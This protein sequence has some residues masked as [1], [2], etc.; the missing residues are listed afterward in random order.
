MNFFEII[1]IVM[2]GLCP[3]FIFRQLVM[4]LVRRKERATAYIEA[5][6]QPIAVVVCCRNE[7]RVIARL[8]SSLQEQ[9][10]RNYRIFVVAHNCTDRTAEIASGFAVKVV[11]L[12]DPSKRRKSDALNRAMEYIL[13]RHPGQFRYVAVFDA[14]SVLEADFLRKMNNAMASGCDVA[15]GRYG[16]LNSR[17]SLVSGLCAGLYMV[18]MKVDSQASSQNRLPVNP[19]GSGFCVRYE[20]VENGW[21]TETL[22]EDFE[23]ANREVLNGRKLVFVPDAVFKTEVPTTLSAAL[24]QRK[25]WVVGQAQC[26]RLYFPKYVRKLRHPNRCLLKQFAELCIYPISLGICA[27]AIGVAICGIVLD[28]PLWNII[29]PVSALCVYAVMVMMTCASFRYC[30]VSCRENAGAIALMPFWVM[31]TVVYSV[32][33]LFRRDMEWQPTE[34]KGITD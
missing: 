21:N 2:V 18:L 8:L 9:N 17:S 5:C 27:G 25:R 28:G 29:L 32:T 10:Y 31:V 34:H 14:D 24:R 12:N 7:E 11:E 13:E 26:F 20:I 30:K 23:L 1:M 22:N 3:L 33:A 4:N 15:S 6:E 16:F 19:Y